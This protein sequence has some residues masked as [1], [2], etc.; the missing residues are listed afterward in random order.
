MS[1]KMRIAVAGAGLIGRRHVELID[2]S[3]DCVLAGIAD[4]SPNAKEFA[5]ARKTPWHA[6]HR[7]LLADEK[8]DGLIIASPNALHFQMA[9]DCAEARV[10]ALIEKPVTD[11]VAAA[12]RLCAAVRRTGVPMLVG[13]HR[14]HNPIIK[15]A[16]EAVT[17]G[18]LGQ[19]TAVVGLWLLKKP[20]DYF[21]V[22]WRREHGGGPL[23]INLIH[24]IDNLRFIC[25]EIAEVQALTSNKA[26]GF[27]VEDTAA[28]LL[29]FECGA[30]GTVAVSDATPAPWSW[31]LTSGE[32]P[33][34]PKQDQPCYIFSG[35]VG[36]LSVPNMELWSYA[37]QSG[38]YAPLARESIAPAA[39]DPLAEQ[40]RH[41]C[42]VIAGREQPLISAEDAMGT[43]AVVEAVSEAA[44]TGQKISPGHIMEQAA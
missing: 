11:T 7:A 37:Q 3:P 13:H 24:D 8:P 26:R 31:E 9:L 4:P 14:R 22:A 23:L 6:D 28:L 29:R 39:V 12:R 18:K 21:D 27:A 16:R 41:F 44:R 30:L 5:Q 38:W 43:L 33:A 25:G 19:L 2:A 42:A 20:D 32:N 35:T 40:L 17:S 1:A 34:Y 36:S 10:P 15:A